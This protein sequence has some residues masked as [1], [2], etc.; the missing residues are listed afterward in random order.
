[1]ISPE[2]SP[3]VPNAA[4]T[5][6]ESLLKNRIT[7]VH[8]LHTVAYGGVET[9]VINWLRALDSQ[10]FDVHLVC[11]AN[12]GGTEVP[13]LEAARRAGLKVRTIRWSRRKPVFRATRELA[14]IL[15]EVKAN[16]VHTYNVYA[17]VVGLLAARVTGAKA[18]S[19]LFVW[20]DFGWK[21]NFLQHVDRWALQHFDLVTAQCEKTRQDTIGRGLPR[22]RTKV[23]ISG[24]DLPPVLP[25][26]EERIRLRRAKGVED[27]QIV[28]ANIARLYPEKAQDLL[29]RSFA[30]LRVKHPEARLWIFGTGPLEASL[31]SLSNRLGLDGEVRFLGF[32][33]EPMAYL[34]LLDVQV[35]PSYAEGVPLALCE[36]LA[37]GL[38]VVASEVGGISEVLDGGRCGILLPSA[39]DPVF[40]DAF[41][42]TLSRLIVQ[43]EERRR[44]GAAGREFI[45]TGYSLQTAVD[46]LERTYLDLVGPCA[47]GSS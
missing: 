9:I 35:H 23:L 10:R 24:F 18:I 8:V 14:R 4:R 6:S 22:E 19:T 40:L 36:G 26:P 39:S 12:P 20:S 21:R 15:R 44:L 1:M 42:D 33:D 43:P 17:D 31:K 25:G 30:T 28:L 37:A 29:L 45:R 41:V 11:F 2:T 3:S 16:V 32:V 47:L 5:V 38:P 7:V 13:F 34:P 27:E 46:E